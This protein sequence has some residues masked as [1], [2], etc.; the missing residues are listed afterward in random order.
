[1]RMLSIAGWALWQADS[2]LRVVGGKVFLEKIFVVVVVIFFYV[3]LL[4]LRER[5]RQST[6]G[7]EADR[8]GDTELEAGSRL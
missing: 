6:S 1:M 5:E 2:E 7:G 3:Y 8:E 4:F